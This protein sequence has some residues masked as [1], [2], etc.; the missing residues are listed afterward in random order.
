MH[1]ARAIRV[2]LVFAGLVGTLVAQ[3]SAKGAYQGRR[4]DPLTYQGPGREDPDPTGISEVKFA[5]FGPADSE[6]SD[7]DSIWEGANLAIEE[8]N[9]DGGYRG[10]RFVLISTWA[11]NPWAGGAAVLIRTLYTDKIWAVIGGVDGATTHLAEQV[12]TKALVTLVNPAATDRSIHSANVPWMFSLAPGDH[13]QT[14]LISHFLR[15][16]AKPFVLVSA[17]DHDSRAYASALKAA[18]AQDHISPLLH[19]E[20][21]DARASADGIAARVLASDAEI[22]VVLAGTKEGRISIKALKDAGFTGTIVAGPL[23]MRA[24]RGDPD[25]SL[26]GVIVPVLG[27]IPP[28]FGD[29]YSARYGTHPDYAAV[30]GYDAANILIK[31]VRQ[32][33]LNRARI[34]DAVRALS[35]YHGITGII[36]WDAVGQNDRGVLLRATSSTRREDAKE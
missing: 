5:Y 12:V 28:D 23:L 30:Y 21:E 3:D 16:H 2:G 1:I 25:A 31:A 35:P 15:D 24:D 17:T 4:T 19:L 7:R 14:P 20:F 33:G 22:T 8:A 27:E 9:K 18:F 11:K 36:Q 26:E 29:T 10:A 6:G 32:A 13:L 34:R